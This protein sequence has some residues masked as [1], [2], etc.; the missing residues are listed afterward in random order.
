VAQ[1]GDE[2]DVGAHD[3][4]ERALRRGVLGKTGLHEQLCT[5]PWL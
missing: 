2:D 5:V 3:R 4:A 1:D